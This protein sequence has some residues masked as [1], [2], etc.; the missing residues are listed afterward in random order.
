MTITDSH[1]AP[2]VAIVGIT[3]KQGGSVARALIDSDKSYRIRG[4]TRDA[5]KPASRAF[6]DL[7]V[8]VVEVSLIVGNEDAVRKAFSGAKIVFAVTNFNEH[9]NKE[10]EIAEGKLMVDAAVSAGVSLFIWSALESISAMSSGRITGVAPF[11]SK[12]AVTAYARDSGIPLAIVQAGY[13]GDNVLLGYPLQPQADGSLLYSLPMPGST[14]VPFIDVE[15]DYGL[16]VRVAIESSALG[17]GSEVL[18]GHLMS[19]DELIAGLA[20]FTGK[21]IIYSQNTRE[22]FLKMFP[23]KDMAPAIADLYQAY[24]EIG[25]YGPKEPTSEDILARKPKTWREFLEAAPRESFPVGLRP[26]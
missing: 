24:E 20:E 2:L 9:F 12:A 16:Y 21:K 22:E 6:T 23:Y 18:S 7:G 14:R 26:A 1:T 19:V 10:R 3:G 8:Q 13:Y 11:D 17:A 15:A 4:L 25:Y 5:N